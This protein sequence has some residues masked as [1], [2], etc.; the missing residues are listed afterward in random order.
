MNWLQRKKAEDT[1]AETFDE[2]DLLDPALRQTL[3]EFKA[4]VHAWSEAELSRPRRV[5]AMDRHRRRALV[6]WSLSA[7]LLIA[8]GGGGT[9]TYHQ[10]EL[11]RQEAARQAQARIAAEKARIAA[12]QEEELFASMDSALSREVPSAMEPLAELADTSE[13]SR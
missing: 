8:T 4:S 5:R 7:A 9:Y 13:T 6:G 1:A 3:S 2:K 12:E 11:A 10:R